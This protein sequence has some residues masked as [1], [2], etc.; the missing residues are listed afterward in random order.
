MR[1]QRHHLG[2]AMRDAGREIS[3]HQR[4]SPEASSVALAA[5]L[6]GRLTTASHAVARS[7]LLSIQGVFVLVGRHENCDV[8]IGSPRVSRQHCCLALDREAL[9]VRDLG[10]SNG[11]WI[12]G[13]RIDSGVM[14]R[15]DRL[16]IAHLGYR[17]EIDRDPGDT[18]PPAPRP[19]TTAHSQPTA[20]PATDLH[21]A[22]AR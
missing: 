3:I 12:N 18:Q 22:F 17:L 16:Q 9:I 21:D 10:S 20:M 19:V 15:G 11:T 8:T 5:Q 13:V 1:V 14:G 7:Q 6:M 2:A 4:S